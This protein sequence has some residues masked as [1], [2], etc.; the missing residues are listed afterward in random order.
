[1]SYFISVHL[2]PLESSFLTEPGMRLADKETLATLLSPY[3]MVQWLQA[4]TSPPGILLG[5][6]GFKL[7]SSNLLS[8]CFDSLSS[9]NWENLLPFCK[10]SNLLIFFHGNL[11]I[12]FRNLM[13]SPLQMRKIVLSRE[14]RMILVDKNFTIRYHFQWGF[15]TQHTVVPLF[16]RESYEH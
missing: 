10:S 1:M 13:C 5:Y 7:R 8:K 2:I 9:S 16:W 14:I 4:Y 6:W 3:I 12:L 11:M 15:P